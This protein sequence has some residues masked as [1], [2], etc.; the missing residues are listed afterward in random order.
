[1]T[2]YLRRWKFSFCILFCLI[3]LW[4]EFTDAKV[5]LWNRIAKN[6]PTQDLFKYDNIRQQSGYRNPTKAFLASG[7]HPGTNNGD[8]FQ[9]RKSQKRNGIR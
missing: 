5:D 8:R 7:I 2:P 6:Y 3:F 1:M 9:F 4:E